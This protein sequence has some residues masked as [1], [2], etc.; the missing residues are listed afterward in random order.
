ML[1][2]VPFATKTPV[3][4][5]GKGLSRSELGQKECAIAEPPRGDL[6]GHNE[7][8]EIS[9]EELVLLLLPKKRLS[10]SL[11]IYRAKAVGDIDRIAFLGREESGRAGGKR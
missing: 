9:P 10:K 3:G 4:V 11:E 7:G 2:R 8:S 5:S 6:S 1:L